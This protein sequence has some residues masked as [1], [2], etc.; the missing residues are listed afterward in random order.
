MVATVGAIFGGIF[1]T[2]LC[3][4]AVLTALGYT[5]TMR[6]SMRIFFI[7]Q[8]G[9]YVPGAI[10]PA[11]AQMRLGREHK[12]PAR[13]SGAAFVLFMVTLMGTGML[14]AVLTLPWLSASDSADLSRYWWTLLVL[15]LVV[16]VVSPPI[17]NRAIGLVLRVARRDPLPTPLTLLGI[18]RAVG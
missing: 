10:W 4:R 7:G 14:V 17:T 11:I 13:A 15:P 16:I 6:G 9:K 5:P 3:W 8:L 12:V 18:L 2:F 1:A